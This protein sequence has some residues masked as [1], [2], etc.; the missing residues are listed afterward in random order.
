MEF[1]PDGNNLVVETHFEIIVKLGFI[2]LADFRHDAVEYWEDG[3]LV[4]FITETKEQDKSACKV[5]CMRRVLLLKVVN[6][7]V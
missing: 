3:R 5:F 2:K 1:F 6:L 4:A 7:V